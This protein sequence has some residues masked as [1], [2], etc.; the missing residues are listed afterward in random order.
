MR[1]LKTIE[2]IRIRDRIISKKYYNTH[3]EI[4]LKKRK[5]YYLT[6]KR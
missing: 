2:E 3:R 5:K 1:I 6:I 4:I